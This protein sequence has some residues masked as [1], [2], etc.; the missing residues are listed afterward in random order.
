MVVLSCA[1]GLWAQSEDV[2]EAG[3]MEFGGEFH[4][5]WI[6]GYRITDADDRDL[7]EGEY[8]LFLD[9]TGNIGLFLKDRLSLQ[10]LPGIFFWRSVDDN[11][12]EIR[13][14][15]NVSLGIGADYYFTGGSPWVFSAGLDTNLV[16]IPGIDGKDSG[17]PESIDSFVMLFEFSPNVTAYYFISERMA[18]FFNL[19]TDFY[20]IKQIKTTSGDSWEY[21]S[22]KGFMNYWEMQ[23]KITL[24]FKYF[25]PTGFRFLQGEE[26]TL[27]D[28]LKTFGD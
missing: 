28:A 11:K 17:S 15:L 23:L 21:P 14:R 2:F 4:L 19:C 3:N 16:F 26:E 10:F 1:A 25:L 22:G 20:N 5:T 7:N 27:T 6:P 18:P 8:D 12:D 24:G 9:A 13:N